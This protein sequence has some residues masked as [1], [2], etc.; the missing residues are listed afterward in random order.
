MD[1]HYYY[2]APQSYYSSAQPMDYEY[3]GQGPTQPRPNQQHFQT[4]PSQQ[5]QGQRVPMVRTFLPFPFHRG[6]SFSQAEGG[7]L[8]D[9]NKPS[10]SPQPGQAP[11]A[12]L[13]TGVL[14]SSNK[15]SDGTLITVLNPPGAQ[16]IGS[17][18]WNASNGGYPGINHSSNN[19]GNGLG[20]GA[21]G[22]G[23]S[24]IP[25]G[26]AVPITP[27]G[28]PTHAN[29]GA[30]SAPPRGATAGPK[31]TPPTVYGD[32]GRPAGGSSVPFGT[33]IAESSEDYPGGAVYSALAGQRLQRQQARQPL[34]QQ[35][36]QPPSRQGSVSVVPPP[37]QFQRPAPQRVG[38]GSQYLPTTPGLH[39]PQHGGQNANSPYE[40]PFDNSWLDPMITAQHQAATNQ[41]PPPPPG[42][43]RPQSQPTSPPFAGHNFSGLNLPPAPNLN[44][45]YMGNG[46]HHPQFAAAVPGA[47]GAHPPQ[48]YPTDPGFGGQFG[49]A[50]QSFAHH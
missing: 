7:G 20:V 44:G 45:H 34:P 21:G 48:F 32:P 3:P 38:S 47:P 15:P 6:L 17:G 33:D 27:Q 26:S 37:N 11:W 4:S 5:N 30:I 18:Q 50:Q 16:V 19:G 2:P 29:V 9:L 42:Q 28:W 14:Q 22:P 49:V 31:T 36:Q 1:H 13:M 35:Q 43:Q 12:S 25:P 10:D 8:G 23:H 40:P 39:P 46:V 41:P 24:Q